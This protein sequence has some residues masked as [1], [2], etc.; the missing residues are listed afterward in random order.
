MAVSV[1]SDST[2]EW[3]MRS[4]SADS[5]TE[6]PALVAAVGAAGATRRDAHAH[7]LAWTLATFCGHRGRWREWVL[8][9]HVAVA[10]ARHCG[11]AAVLPRRCGCSDRPTPPA[12]GSSR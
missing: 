6:L 2:S 3:L 10:S 8:A 11:D 12:I 4:T 5:P 9:Q 1:E 7:Q